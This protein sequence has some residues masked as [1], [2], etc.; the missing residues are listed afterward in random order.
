MTEADLDA[1][2]G[3]AYGASVGLPGAERLDAVE[4]AAAAVPVALLEARRKGL[5]AVM[6]RCA[7][8]RIHAQFIDRVLSGR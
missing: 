6:G 5:A 3:R 8:S 1:L 2:L 4:Q 7:V